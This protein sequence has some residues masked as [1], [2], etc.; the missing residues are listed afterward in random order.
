M[1]LLYL[2]SDADFANLEYIYISALRSRVSS[3]F[4]VIGFS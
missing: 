1:W 3:K 2:E 4:E